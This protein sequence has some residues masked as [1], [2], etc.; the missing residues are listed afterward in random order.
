MHRLNILKVFVGLNIFTKIFDIYGLD[1][2]FLFKIFFGFL[3]GGKQSVACYL[4]S[5]SAPPP[6]GRGGG[7]GRV[8]GRGRGRGR[9]GGR[10]G[11]AAWSATPPA[12]PCARSGSSGRWGPGPRSARWRTATTTTLTI[13]TLKHS[14][15][16][17]WTGHRTLGVRNILIVYFPCVFLQIKIAT[18]S[19]LT[20][21]T[22][23]RL[24]IVVRVH[25]EC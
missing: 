23:I 1:E 20:N 18:K 10:E 12:P 16:T 17:Y 5:L 19:L 9:G 13:T 21:M 8:R 14:H 4:F 3:F 11:G 24:V 22:S 7:E 25:V 2:R 15:C 6:P